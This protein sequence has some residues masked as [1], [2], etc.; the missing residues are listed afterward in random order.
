MTDSDS[1]RDGTV[2]PVAL[3]V[4]L[5]D[6]SDGSRGSDPTTDEL[7]V[8]RLGPFPADDE[9]FCRPPGGGVEFGETTTD[10]VVREFE[11]EL[12]ATVDVEA[13]LGVVE[14]RFRF[15]GDAHHEHCFVYAVAF[16]DDARYDRESMHG[17]EDD[18]DVEYDTEWATL[19]DLAAREEPLYPGGL[20][21]LLE[22][23]ATRVA[24]A[25]D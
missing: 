6:P 14:N 8:A 19:D 17:V 3:G 4:A 21:E 13:F 12:G 10:A 18:S 16:A 24:S 15:A 5:R 1:T 20:R 9:V 11:E 25:W 2:D 7:L 22:S 23:D